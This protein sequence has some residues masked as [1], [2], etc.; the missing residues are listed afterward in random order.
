VTVACKCRK[1]HG[2]GH[3]SGGGKGLAGLGAA[4]A[5]GVYMAS[6]AHPHAAKHAAPTVAAESV[7][8]PPAQTAPVATGAF[9]GRSRWAS[10]FLHDAGL[11]DTTCDVNAIV[12]WEGAEN[13]RAR[14]NPLSS[15]RD[16]PGATNFNPG[17]VKD[18]PTLAEGL[19][20]TVATLDNGAYPGVIAA[21]R[22]GNNAELVAQ[23]IWI[24]HTWGTEPF[25]AAC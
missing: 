17:G 22:A 8:A 16:Q 23:R 24:P 3:G 20:A 2:G 18:Y 5:V 21:L 4:V 12:A 6:A 9:P 11:P 7:A 14:F 10:D 25:S 13:T 15:E 19:Q 1:H